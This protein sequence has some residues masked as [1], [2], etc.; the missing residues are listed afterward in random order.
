MVSFTARFNDSLYKKLKDYAEQ[1]GVSVMGAI[2]LI[3]NNF[4]RMQNNTGIP[5]GR[6]Q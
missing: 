5:D 4:F 3:C 1:N 2:R 6:T